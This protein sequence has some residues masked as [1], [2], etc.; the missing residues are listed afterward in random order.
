MK[1]LKARILLVSL[2]ALFVLSGC[3]SPK[4]RLLGAS[5]SLFVPEGTAISINGPPIITEN[6]G[7]YF[8]EDTLKDMGLL[9]LEEK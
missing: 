1:P 9:L 7:Y 6:D 2:I 8:D 4:F 5:D 3:N